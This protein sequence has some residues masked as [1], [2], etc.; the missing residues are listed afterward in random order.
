[1]NSKCLI[2]NC[3]IIQLQDIRSD[4][5]EG[6]DDED[7]TLDENHLEVLN[8]NFDNNEMNKKTV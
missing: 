5:E 8:N 1:M 2:S 7:N 3:F 4:T 6:S